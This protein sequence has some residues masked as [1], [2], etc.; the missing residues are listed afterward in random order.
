[1]VTTVAAHNPSVVAAAGCWGRGSVLD[2]L[3]LVTPATLALASVAVLALLA[4]CIFAIG[5]AASVEGKSSE[6]RGA[7]V[8]WRSFALS[9]VILFLGVFSAKLL[10][11]RQNPVTVPYWDQWNGEAR[12]LYLPFNECS[13]TWREMFSQ[14]NEHRFFFSRVLALDLLIANGQW[15]PRLQQVVNATLHSL[16]AVLVVAMLWIAQE[17][18][19]LSLLL[20]IGAAT[21]ALP[22]A[23]ENTL[24]GFQSGFYFLLLFSLLG[25]WLTTKH[26][27]WTRQWCLGCLCALCGL[28]TGASGLVLPVALA[29]VAVLTL[30]NDRQSWNESRFTLAAAATIF[31]L[32]FLIASSPLPYHE[33]LKAQTVL[34]FVG[35]LGRN[36]AWPLVGYWQ[37]SLVMW[38]PVIALLF[39]L[40]IRRSKATLLERFII[41]LGFWVA[42][43]AG[44]LAY[45]RGAGAPTPA[46]RYQDFLSL[47]FV[48]NAMA[49]LAGLDRL[50]SGPVTRR[51][52]VCALVSWFLVPVVGLHQLVAEAQ[53]TVSVWRQYWSAQASSVR[54]FVIAGNV[55]EFTSRRPVEQ[56][57]FPDAQILA[58]LLR[59]PHIRR[60]LPPAVREPVRVEP[61]T[62]THDAFVSEGVPPSTARD[63]TMRSWGSFT[64]K[65]ARAGGRFESYPIE[66]CRFGGTLQFEVAGYFSSRHQ[67][68]AVKD[69]Q[70]GRE[71]DVKPAALTE[72][73]WTRALVSCPAGPYAIMAVD[74]TSDYWLSFREPVEVGR[75]SPLTEWLITSSPTFFVSVLALGLLATG[76]Y[77]ARRRLRLSLSA[78]GLSCLA[79]ARM[80]QTS[81]STNSESL[82]RSVHYNL[83]EPVGLGPFSFSA[84]D[85]FAIAGWAFLEPA[86]SPLPSIS[87]ECVS[88]RTGAVTALDVRRSPR[89]D[90]VRHFGVDGLEMSGFATTLRIDHRFSG[91]QKVRLVLNEHSQARQVRELFSFG[92]APAPYEVN[93]RRDLA[94]R[95]LCGAGLEVGALHRRLDVP[96]HCSVTYVDRLALQDL[97]AHYP[98]L[99]GQPVQAPD[100][101]DNGET[102]AKVGT[103]S[104]DFVIAN[105]FLEHC[106]NPIQTMLNFMRVLKD[107]G[108]LYMAVPDKRF[109]FDIDRPVTSYARLAETFRQGHR[110]DRE[111]LYV[112]WA[113]CVTRASVSEAPAVGRKLL[114]EQ[115][116]IHFNVW[117]LADLF[118]FASKCKAEFGLPFDLEWLVCSENEVILILRKQVG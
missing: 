50:G 33:V 65:G 102:L 15:D 14:H 1:L 10:L 34:D 57:P 79:R 3:S 75:A 6:R 63:S 5:N 18:R 115:Y 41:G 28:F 90:V 59:E 56:L 103:A 52:A 117:A 40:T 89:P 91:E 9:I 69:L 22:F 83:D 109:T 16:V 74:A 111:A 93:V 51:I 13:L 80:T 46:A 77:E 11:M 47:G 37:L 92:V 17:G 113:A 81:I 32:G 19:R 26:S 94:A 24:L 4:A 62:V 98:E 97:L 70:S 68:L 8:R 55:A 71:Q 27:A 104:Q 82:Q 30:L 53:A 116:S 84:G 67:Y 54:R 23:W 95:F 31:V 114:A 96:R 35:A 43:Q 99:K 106:E 76:G 48:A 86:G 78:G 61:R 108:I 45:G 7:G 38:L 12:A 25:L 64:K 58:A 42:L 21:F 73:G 110:S 60:I 66:S 29:G 85:E 2:N 118:E 44:A 72:E 87:L 36:L 105:H 39:V 107:D 88:L 49:A 112:E 100:L 101:I 20:F